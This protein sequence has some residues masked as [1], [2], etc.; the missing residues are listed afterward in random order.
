MLC[1][2]KEQVFAVAFLVSRDAL[3]RIELWH[4]LSPFGIKKHTYQLCSNVRQLVLYFHANDML[5]VM[6]SLTI[7]TKSIAV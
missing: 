1:Q 5:I 3:D 4:S 6:T 7:A 2:L